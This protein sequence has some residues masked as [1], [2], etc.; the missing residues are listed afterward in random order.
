MSPFFRAIG[1]LCT[2]VRWS[3]LL[4][5]LKFSAL[6]SSNFR[7]RPSAVSYFTANLTVPSDYAQT[8]HYISFFSDWVALKIKS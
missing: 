6:E 7:Y 2:L 8:N 3:F 4:P 5:K 1:P